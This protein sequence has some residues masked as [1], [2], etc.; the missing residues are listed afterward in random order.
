M[1]GHGNLEIDEMVSDRLRLK[2]TGHGKIKLGH[3]KAASV[4]VV[5]FGHGDIKISGTATSQ[6]VKIKGHGRYDATG[7]ESSRAELTS[8]GFGRSALWVRDQLILDA[9][10]F[11]AVHY[12]GQPVV[13]SAGWNR[14][15]AA[16]LFSSV[17]AMSQEVSE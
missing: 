4:D 1:D 9:Q 17:P 6:H 7:L 16:D 3:V 11:G 2:M 14:L 13:H 8:Q 10:E 15:A 12:Q 5:M